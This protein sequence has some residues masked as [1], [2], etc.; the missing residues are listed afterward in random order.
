MRN[1]Q[2]VEQ[3]IAKLEGK[4]KHALTLNGENKLMELFRVSEI[5]G[6]YREILMSK[7]F[8][9]IRMALS[10]FLN[11]LDDLQKQTDKAITETLLKKG[12]EIYPSQ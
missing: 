3:E 4:L 10:D 9:M 11:K 7:Q 1:I 5:I 2:E 12:N 8:N 6:A